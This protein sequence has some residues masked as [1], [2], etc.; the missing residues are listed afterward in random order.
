MNVAKRVNKIWPVV[1]VS[2][3]LISILPVHSPVFFSETCPDFFVPLRAHRIKE[4]LLL[5]AGS[6]V[7]CSRNIYRLTN[8]NKKH[9]LWY[10]DL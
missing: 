5:D 3:L 4:A 9:D 10:D 2:S 7:G 1:S 8:N 6:R